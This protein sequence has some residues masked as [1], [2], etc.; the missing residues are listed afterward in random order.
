MQ[1]EFSIKKKA[2][3]ESPTA[4]L[5]RFALITTSLYMQNMRSSGLVVTCF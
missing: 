5:Y 3:I 4:G 2:V 1:V